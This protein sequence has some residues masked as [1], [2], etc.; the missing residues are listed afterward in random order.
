MKTK[1]SAYKKEKT[2]AEATTVFISF[3]KDI[4]RSPNPVQNEHEQLLCA[5][6]VRPWHAIAITHGSNRLS[7]T[8]ISDLDEL[9]KK[10]DKKIREWQKAKPLQGTKKTATALTVTVI[11]SNAFKTLP[12]P[13]KRRSTT[14]KP[15][16]ATY[17]VNG[18]SL[19]RAKVSHFIDKSKL[20]A[21]IS[22]FRIDNAEDFIEAIGK[23]FPQQIKKEND[24]P[25][26]VFR[27][28]YQLL[29][30]SD[31]GVKILF[32]ISDHNINSD[33]IFEDIEEAYSIA[34]KSR[35]SPNTFKPNDLTVTEYVYFTENCD[36]H[37]YR[38]IAEELYRFLETSEWDDSFV[39]AD[40]VNHSPAQGDS[41]LD[42]VE[43]EKTDAEATT[44]F[45]SFKKD[46]RRSPN[47]VQNEHE[48]LLCAFSV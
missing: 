19:A 40:R 7:G 29:D 22:D 41:H 44:V 3:K 25:D 47:P 26:E 35:K 32:R 27:S 18:T 30:F 5:F 21:L 20:L 12:Q 23:C 16:L 45:I 15:R 8:N 10:I 4:R 37:R 31:L 14:T 48:Q 34:L 17:T 43:K 9:R 46:I 36:R 6:S 28:K 24:R 39:P 13:Y 1:L 42:G 11:K 38:L 33:N 2:D